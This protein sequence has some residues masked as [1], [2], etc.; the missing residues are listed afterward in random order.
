MELGASSTDFQKSYS[1]FVLSASWIA[2]ETTAIALEA[3][4]KTSMLMEL[5]LWRES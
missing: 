5:Y 4:L 1:F 3:P 2:R